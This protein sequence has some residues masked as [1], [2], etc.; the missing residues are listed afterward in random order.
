M[1]R[2]FRGSAILLSMSALALIGCVD[3]GDVDEDGPEYPGEQRADYDPSNPRTCGT[4]E[5]DEV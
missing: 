1:R 4:A 2:L 3:E 5:L